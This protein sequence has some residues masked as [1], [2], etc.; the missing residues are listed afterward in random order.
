M[1]TFFI[2]LLF[3]VIIIFLFITS[4]KKI[5][6]LENRL[7]GISDIDNEKKSLLKDVENLKKEMNLE[8]EKSLKLIDIKKQLIEDISLLEEDQS[9][10]EFSFYKPKYYYENSDEYKKAINNVNLQQKEM[11]KNETAAYCTTE[12]TVENSK[13]KGKKMTKDNL[14]LM[15]RAFNGEAD[16][17]IA[18]VKYNNI[19]VME[20]RITKAFDTINKLNQ[21]NRCYI[22]TEYLNLKLKELDLNYELAEKLQEE[23]EEQRQIREQMREEERAQREFEKAQLEAKKEEERAQKALEKAKEKLSKAHGKELETLNS[24]IEKLKEE[25]NNAIE[26][27]K[28]ATSMA[29]LTKAGHVYVISNIGSF[30]ENVYKIGMTRRLEPMDRI[31]ELGN[32]SVPFNFDVH[33]M[34]YSENAPE[35]EN[36]L[37]KA[38]YEYRVNKINDRREFF[39]ISLQ[40]IEDVAKEY[41]ADVIFTHLADAE[42]YRQ[43]LAIEKE[44]NKKTKEDYINSFDLEK[45]AILNL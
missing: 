18:K 11:I 24:Q 27:G 21:V 37:H 4:N 10:Q 43:T 28:R 26:Q 14:K 13:S 16:S 23:K 7:D 33:A 39:K 1:F 17:A 8:K 35:L 44:N 15:L 40:E 36:A 45:E 5:K 31:Y 19:K 2:S 41:K 30:G 29:Q 32:A 12:W 38:F 22:S 6:D 3:I 20:N 34:I 25:L 9:L 42:Q